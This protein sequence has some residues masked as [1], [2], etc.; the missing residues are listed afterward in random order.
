LNGFRFDPRGAAIAAGLLV[1]V[2]LIAGV[3][4]GPVSVSIDL[5]PAVA[6]T[7]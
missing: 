2:V 3:F 5:P 7:Q 6:E 4:F 1:V